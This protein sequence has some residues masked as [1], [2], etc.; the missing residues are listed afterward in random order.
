MVE[1]DLM[2]VAPVKNVMLVGPMV[3]FALVL[4]ASALYLWRGEAH[5]RRDGESTSA[6]SKVF[7]I[8]L[9]SSLSLVSVKSVD[10]GPSPEGTVTI[11]NSDDAS[12]SD[13]R[14]DMA[15]IQL[16]GLPPLGADQVYEGWFVSDDG[17][18]KKSVGI[19]GVSPEG[20]IDQRFFAADGE[21]LLASFDKFVV[22]IEPVPDRNPFP[23]VDVIISRT[24]PPGGLLHI[25]HLV[26][27]WQGNPPYTAGLH[28]GTPKGIAVG[29][30]EQTWVALFHAR[31]S[32]HSVTLAEVLQHA[33]H[34]VN[35]VERGP[36]RDL[37]GVGGA[38][39]PGDGFGV[40]PYAEDAALH[41]SLAA[42]AA[43]DDRVIT[44][45]SQ[46][47]VVEATQ[48]LNLSAQ[49]RDMALQA[50][51]ATTRQRQGCT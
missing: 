10:V 47:V 41:A 35:I 14:S 12:Y 16:T 28:K 50:L 33:E 51:G 17:T 21:N 46:Q 25:R 19:L 34:V 29:L 24:I 22:T 32:G 23:S 20:N 13:R 9:S 39:N 30:R 38:Q 6:V 45:H 7:P 36:A 1:S 11:R 37:D 49:A 43:P 27:S 15:R 42:L 3:A 5:A 8:A 40:L 2:I 44:E 18:R 4:V 31:L 48:V 26:Y